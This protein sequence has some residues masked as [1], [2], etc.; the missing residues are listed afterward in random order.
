MIVTYS[1]VVVRIC[2]VLVEPRQGAQRLPR[3]KYALFECS[4]SLNEHTQLEKTIKGMAFSCFIG[5]R[6]IS[7]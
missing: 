1:E 2:T 5:A 7:E 6:E 3:M 4:C